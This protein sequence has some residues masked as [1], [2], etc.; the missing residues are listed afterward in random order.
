MRMT[1]PATSTCA[2]TRKHGPN[3][4]SY[5]NFKR[6]TLELYQGALHV[7]AMHTHTGSS[8]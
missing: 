7:H 4:Q 2:Q 1:E 8:H 6:I 3:T 5:F